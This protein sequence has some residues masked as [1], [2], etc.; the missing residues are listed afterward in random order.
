LI[1]FPAAEAVSIGRSEAAAR[2]AAAVALT[3]RP[4]HRA[5]AHL[6]GESL[7]RLEQFGVAHRQPLLVDPG[8]MRMPSHRKSPSTD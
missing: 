1:V 5:F 8:K 3:G 4:P 6:S 2:P 7:R